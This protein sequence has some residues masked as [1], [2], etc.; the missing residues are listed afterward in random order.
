MDFKACPWR[1]VSFGFL[2]AF[3]ATGCGRMQS[4]NVNLNLPESMF[5]P[6]DGALNP[7]SDKLTSSCVDSNEFDACVIYK[8]PVAQ[9][10]TPTG[11]EQINR[12]R[13][14]GVKIR[15]LA[16]TGFLENG[17]FQVLT[18]HT[19]RFSL[20]EP[21]RFKSEYDDS[22][23]FLEQV[24]TYYWANRALEFVVR[25][26][27]AD[28]VPLS[29]LRIFVDDVFTGYVSTRNAIHLERG[30]GRIPSAL[31]SDILIHLL[32]EALAQDLAGRAL[33]PSAPEQ[34]KIC[35]SQKFG[36][37]ASAR[38]CSQ[39][40]SLAFGDYFMAM[41]F[42]ASPRL[43]ESL[44]QSVDGQMICNVRRRDLA[45]FE[46]LSAENA[47]AA[48]G[49][50]ASGQTVIM[51]GWYAGLWWKLRREAEA[52]SPGTGERDIDRLFFLH[53]KQWTSS[54]TFAQ[55]ANAAIQA[56]DNFKSG[57]YKSAVTQALLGVPR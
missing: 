57:I 52:K 15:G 38:G 49:G 29:R 34:H 21:Q 27:G 39:A 12:S 3:L 32:G 46:G 25:Q 51:G 5:A 6:G 11:L 36:C 10:R 24:Q 33:F 4:L 23:S 54:S 35:M 44:A 40:L 8:N 17:R 30:R 18:L 7:A 19:P 28:L 13:R 37:C 50:H 56:A 2:A 47:Y 41:V 14:Y 43:G 22:V 1:A 16:R 31:S 20:I 26:V 48:C 45:G 42:P 53:A 55:A 9:E